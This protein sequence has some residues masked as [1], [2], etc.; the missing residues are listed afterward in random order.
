MTNKNSYGAADDLEA[1]IKASHTK[2]AA[3]RPRRFA[4]IAR[5]P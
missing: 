3:D 1:Q 2:D 5:T 4:V